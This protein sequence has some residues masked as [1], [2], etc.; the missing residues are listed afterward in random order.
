MIS[1]A[2][3]AHDE[4]SSDDDSSSYYS[5]S[6]SHDQDTTMIADPALMD[7]VMTSQVGSP[8]IGSHNAK[9]TLTDSTLLL[10]DLSTV[11]ATA[12]HLVSINSSL[13]TPQTPSV[14]HMTV[15][16]NLTSGLTPPLALLP[17]T[18]TG[19]LS[20][21]VA[22]VVGLSSSSNLKNVDK[23][24]SLNSSGSSSLTSEVSSGTSSV[25][26]LLLNGGLQA[27]GGLTPT[28]GL[29]I[30]NSLLS[31]TSLIGDGL[32]ANMGL[33]TAAVLSLSSG[34]TTGGG[35]LSSRG[36]ATGGGL[37]SS[38]GLMMGGVLSLS[39]GST[40][41]GDLLSS[42]DL[43]LTG[44]LSTS[45][46]AAEG[47]LLFANVTAGG[48]LLPG[49]GLTHGSLTTGE[50][51]ASNN[52][53]SLGGLSAGDLLSSRSL[54]IGGGVL[55][56]GVFTAGGSLTSGSD[57]NN[58]GLLT[59]GMAEGVPLAAR[60]SS[61]SSSITISGLPS[62][63]NFG[64]LPSSKSLTTG[65]GLLLSGNLITGGVTKKSLDIEDS[66]LSNRDQPTLSSEQT[67]IQG[68]LQSSVSVTAMVTSP[69]G[70]IS[71]GSLTPPSGLTSSGSLISASLGKHGIPYTTTGGL[72]TSGNFYLGSGLM[73][74]SG[75]S[76][77][78][79][80]TSVGKDSMAGAGLHVDA[81]LSSSGILVTSSG[82][83]PSS[84][85]LTV[86]GLKLSSGLSP[87]VTSEIA[88]SMQH[89]VS[90]SQPSA[91]TTTN[92]AQWPSHVQA[93]LD[94]STFDADKFLLSLQTNYGHLTQ[95]VTTA[96]PAVTT[97][98]TANDELTNDVAATSDIVLSSVS[99]T[100]SEQEIISDDELVT[101]DISSQSSLTNVA[102]S[103]MSS[104][105][106]SAVASIVTSSLS[107][108][109]PT[110]TTRSSITPTIHH[111]ATV[112][113][114]P[115]TTSVSSLSTS[116]L[117][118]T[119]YS[120]SS[121]I[122]APHDQLRI[123]TPRL[124]V[125]GVTASMS[126]TN[127]LAGSVN[128]SSLHMS[129]LQDLERETSTPTLPIT[130]IPTATTHTSWSKMSYT[131]SSGDSSNVISSGSVYS[132]STSRSAPL[133]SSYY[134]PLS[135][136]AGATSSLRV[137]SSLSKVVCS[138]GTANV[139]RQIFPSSNTPSITS[140]SNS[141]SRHNVSLV[142][143]SST[144]DV[145]VPSSADVSGVKQLKALHTPSSVTLSKPC[146]VGD[147][148]QTHIPITNS[149]ERWIQ[150]KA[151]VIQVYR[152]N[153]QVILTYHIQCVYH[154]LE[155]D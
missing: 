139:R 113:T 107:I 87:S 119:L 121:L 60:M 155:Y 37:L 137:S 114:L 42:S 75:L 77:L 32:T 153:K 46:L 65:G 141:V 4:G 118:S 142:Y 50:G 14:A 28:S 82:Y 84:G 7:N 76:P 143:L 64:V 17:T 131:R 79:G 18:T 108:S 31:S 125:V 61:S 130:L 148:V 96:M 29:N 66:L 78:K 110:V 102:G 33:T 59:A 115:S 40:T 5:S 34:L 1:P 57:L 49:G 88:P 122:S 133:S 98:A 91:I 127:T 38:S 36:I 68:V 106:A 140:P 93:I 55:S 103:L 74:S 138:S 99:S 90:H 8:V 117:A 95:Q 54:T 104:K 72:L 25:G 21:S 145:A 105:V 70:L 124:S 26:D 152:D 120:S 126:I 83:S 53:L 51:L 43:K 24:S 147:S 154:I 111:L 86:S 81:A 150:C 73:S 20:S 149:C 151:Q 123:I 92:T 41:G 6:S 52:G 58:E 97:A 3:T 22:P 48:G 27:G 135:A 94:S 128:S 144:S 132:L 15:D 109:K 80:S 63:S 44:G 12:S 116:T 69:S 2:V 89:G 85:L 100:D 136:S 30:G 129:S 35:L 101:D 39:S 112:L 9:L 13:L 11:T 19:V 16:F 71:S 45:N 23:A 47:E 67:S 146:C 56:G 10:P 62:C 134:T